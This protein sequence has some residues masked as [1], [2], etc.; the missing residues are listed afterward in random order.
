MMF[1]LTRGMEIVTVPVVV[2]PSGTGTAPPVVTVSG[3]SAVG[4]KSLA[5][6]V[7]FAAAGLA[8]F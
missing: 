5:G 3:A 4:A 6:L 1:R 2:S 8:F 7:A